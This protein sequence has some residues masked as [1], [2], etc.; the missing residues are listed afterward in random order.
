MCCEKHSWLCRLNRHSLSEKSNAIDC[1]NI[2]N[3]LGRTN[4]IPWPTNCSIQLMKSFS[5]LQ[6][7]Q[8]RM[9]RQAVG[10]LSHDKFFAQDECIQSQLLDRQNVYTRQEVQL[11]VTEQEKHSV[12]SIELKFTRTH[13]SLSDL[14]LLPLKHFYNK[15]QVRSSKEKKI[16]RVARN[17]QISFP[18]LFFNSLQL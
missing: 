5:G 9:T 17:E 13:K 18:P 2:S 3:A 15:K 7:Q 12:K 14:V 11:F 6:T 16:W 1:Y 8:F 4:C 10:A